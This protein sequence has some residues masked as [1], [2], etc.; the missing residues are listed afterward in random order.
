MDKDLCLALY[1]EAFPEPDEPFEEALFEKC[2]K[3]CYY[4]KEKG[5]VISMLFA[6]PCEFET[7]KEKIA[8]FYIYAAATLKEYRGLGYMARLMEEVKN[9]KEFLFLRPA[10]D[11]LIAFY[12]K[13]G[14]KTVDAKKINQIP[15][16]T[17]KDDFLR[18]IEIF[19]EDANGEKYTAM[20]FSKTKNL[21]DI[22]FIYT[23]E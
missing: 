5:K 1:R 2:F 6:L 22:N 14:F 8:C 10:E 18:L 11:N 3:Y 19:P 15:H 21:L 20:Y 9:D 4:I 17:P 7:E 23:M 12:K 16:I 13:I